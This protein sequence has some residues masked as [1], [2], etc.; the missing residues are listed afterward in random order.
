MTAIITRGSAPRLLQDGLRDIF[1][2][3]L[4][5]HESKYDKI[6]K[7]SDSRKAF[8][9][10]LQMTGFGR[11]ST[12]D[13]GDDITFDTMQQGI[14]PKYL[15]V[16]VAKGYIITE[17][18]QEDDLYDQYSDGARALADSLAITRELDAHSVLNNGFDTGYTMTNGDGLPLFSTAH[19]NGGP[20]GGTY[21]NRLTIDA[22]LSEASLE[23]LLIQIMN[24]TDER[25]LQRPLMA[26]RLIA[27]PAN[28]FNAHRI[29][30]SSLQSG[31]ANNDTNAVKDMG[32]V[33]NG[34]LI[35][36]YLTDSDA[37]FLTTN[38]PKGLK[39]YQRVAPQFGQ[40]N[41]FTSGNARYKARQR[42]SYGWSAAAG[43]YGS[44]GA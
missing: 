8:E 23:D 30:K 21:S 5:M 43:I 2:N 9:I 27:A 40:D 31:T 17:E 10:D 26:E 11:A 15:H 41:A 7:V 34:V 22:D 12:K 29:M 33:K 35:S 42:Y 20:D 3:Q 28:A 18:A 37:W 1:N 25:G 44:Q 19:L 14:S 6:F 13:E 36:P 24:F 16:T 39:F 4:G 32:M 38:H